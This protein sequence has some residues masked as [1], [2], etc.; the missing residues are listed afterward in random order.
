MTG[1]KVKKAG[2]ALSVQDSGR[3]G[4]LES[5]VSRGGAADMRAVAEGAALLRQ[6]PDLAVLEMA[7][8]GGSFEALGDV[9]IALS[10]APMTATLDGA[11][12]AWNASHQL[13]AGQRLEIGGVR[14]GVYG[15]LHLGGGVD[16]PM[17]LGARSVHLA[18]DLGRRT[19]AGDVLTA[20]A[21]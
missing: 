19:K 12:L 18:A 21:V 14:Q 2:P 8:L 20:G 10:G 6:S 5:G 7:G 13:V 15:Y 11:P 17:L 9:C 3:V 1:I 4:L 16:T